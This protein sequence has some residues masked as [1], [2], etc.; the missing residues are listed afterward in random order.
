MDVVSVAGQYVFEWDDSKAAANLERHGIGFPE[1][2]EV[3][4][5]PL[6]RYLEQDEIGGEERLTLLGESLSLRLVLVVHTE[7][8]ERTRIVSARVA[9][10]HERRWYEQR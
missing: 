8:G 2:T 5:D 4:L 9:T 7:R 10:A 6:A 3:F 1:A